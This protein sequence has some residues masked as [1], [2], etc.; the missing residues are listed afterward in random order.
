[1]Q[2]I[3]LGSFELPLPNTHLSV[4]EKRLLEKEGIEVQSLDL[5]RALSDGTLAYKN[6]RVLVHIR[7]ISVYG[8][9]S[10]NS[11]PKFHVAD[12]ST[13]A[14]MRAKERFGRYVI[15]TRDDGLFQIRKKSD[16]SGWRTSE[17][18]L[19]VC[20]NCLDK[21]RFDGYSHNLSQSMKNSIFS[22]FSIVE[23]FSRY[24]KALLKHRPVHSDRSAPLDD[25]PTNWREISEDY[26]ATVNWSCERCGVV[27]A[28]IKLKRYLHVHHRNGQKFDCR[29]AN[30]QA[31]CL[32]HHAEQPLHGHLKNADYFHFLAIWS[33]LQKGHAAH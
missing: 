9:G 18:G 21:L 6:S 25:Y 26:K 28:D 12:C 7:D 17:V 19:D 15:A 13:L 22:S 33:K 4:D 31:L 20:K 1:M 11:M 30:L 16:A 8:G 5:I 32:K 29:M 3:Q 24:P 14:D 2:A 23:Y 27:L 10:W